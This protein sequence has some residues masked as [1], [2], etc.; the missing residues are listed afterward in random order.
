[1]DTLKSECCFIFKLKYQASIKFVLNVDFDTNIMLNIL[2]LPDY[3]IRH[4]ML[5]NWFLETMRRRYDN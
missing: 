3:M 4:G 1:M 2:N 5:E